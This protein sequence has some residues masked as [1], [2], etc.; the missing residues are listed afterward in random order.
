MYSANG[1]PA[2]GSDDENITCLREATTESLT[3]IF[4]YVFLYD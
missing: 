2:A 1:G 3:R 4:Y